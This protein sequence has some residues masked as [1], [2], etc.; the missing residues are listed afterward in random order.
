MNRT[1]Q[2]AFGESRFPE[3]HISLGGSRVETQLFMC[4]SL[5]S[6]F[7]GL[8]WSWRCPPPNCGELPSAC[9]NWKDVEEVMPHKAPVN[10]TELI[11]PEK[12]LPFPAAVGNRYGPSFVG[13]GRSTGLAASRASLLCVTGSGSVPSLQCPPCKP[14]GFSEK[15]ASAFRKV[16]LFP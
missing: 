9:C 6:A 14:P 13:G 11:I 1:V 7:Q 15:L 5:L 16:P 4:I 10:K 12:S 3:W 2:E 8:A